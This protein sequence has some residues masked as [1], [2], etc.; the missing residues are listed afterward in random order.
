M[1]GPARR[2]GR[3]LLRRG[4]GGIT[5]AVRD[6]RAAGSTADTGSTANTISELAA[7]RV[8]VVIPALNEAENLPSVLATIP[9]DV[10]EI[11]LVDGAST[12]ETIDVARR[13]RSDVRIVVQDASGK[14][15]ALACGFAAASGD[16]IVMLDAD[17]SANGAEIPRFVKAL[18]EGAD[19]A[20]GSRFIGGGGSADITVL[21][22]LGNRVLRSLV[23]LLFK[24]RYTDLCYGYNAF[25]RR[26]LPHLCLDCDGFEVETL[27][28][29]RA[30][31]TNLT[32]REVP[33]YEERRLHGQSHLRVIRDG[34][35]ILRIIF[36]ERFKDPRSLALLPLDPAHRLRGSRVR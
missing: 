28:N 32:V 31:R 6:E 20:K 18:Q 33:S 25:W 10:F 21:R 22:S 9:E 35:R 2:G 3:H 5:D 30:A 7:A 4:A 29:I 8:S 1:P 23:N 17:G 12:D 11:V 26:C 27:L 14:G 15:N 13:C 24:T 34:C 19:L 16:I 36:R